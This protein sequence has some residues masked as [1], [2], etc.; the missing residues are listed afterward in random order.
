MRARITLIT[1]FVMIILVTPAWQIAAAGGQVVTDGLL[2]Y[3]DFENIKDDVVKDVMG[4]RDGTIIP[5]GEAQIV[6]GKFGEAL[7]F[8]MSYYIEFDDAGLPMEKEE[9]TMSAWVKPE[10]AGVRA[11]VEWGAA[12][13]GQRCSI[14]VLAAEKIKF[15]GNNAD[16]TSNSSIG[17]GEWSLITETYDGTTI[18][19][20]L[21]GELD[22]EQAMVINTQPGIGRIGTHVWP[23]LTERFVGAI[24]EVSIYNRELSEDEVAQNFEA[25]RGPTAV[26]PA[27]KLALTWGEVKAFR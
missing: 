19:I 15:C 20:Y 1:V 22:K 16:V 17:L 27:E 5:A 18:R 23:Q 8:D 10:G 9:R 4:N 24:D 12:V 11:V 13:Q 21:N 7:Q 14:L 6:E 26:S 2:D 3:W 25:S